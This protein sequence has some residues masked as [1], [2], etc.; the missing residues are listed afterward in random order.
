[1][2]AWWLRQRGYGSVFELWDAAANEAEEWLSSC[3]PPFWGRSGR[4]RPA[5]IEH[6]R[7]TERELAPVAGIRP[8]SAFQIGGAGSVG[9]G[10]L[11]GMAILARLRREGFSVW[12]FEEPVPPVVVEI[13]PRVLTRAVHKSIRRERARYLD[14]FGA[15]IPSMLRSAAASGEDAF[16]AVVSAL[17]MSEH[18]DDLRDLRAATDPVAALEGRI[19]LPRLR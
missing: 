10:S 1:M 9:T 5:G 3:T 15:R 4:P 7:R 16:D 2:P 13:Y 12:P 11:R 18:I 17:V 14:E 6:F 19:W 8:K